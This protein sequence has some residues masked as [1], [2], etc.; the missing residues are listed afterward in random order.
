MSAKTHR[1]GEASHWVTA[2]THE[3]EERNTDAK[4]HEYEE[5]HLGR[6]ARTVRLML[7]PDTVI[8]SGLQQLSWMELR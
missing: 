2:P 7:I 6:V 8:G 5:T 1:I 3:E 4:N